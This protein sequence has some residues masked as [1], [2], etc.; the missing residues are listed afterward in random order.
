VSRPA[1]RNVQG[2]GLCCVDRVRPAP[3]DWT[4]DRLEVSV[5][6]GAR[7]L[8]LPAEV[9]AVAVRWYLRHGLSYRDVEELLA[10]R[11][12]QVDRVTVYRWVH[13][14]RTLPL[15]ATTTVIGITTAPDRSTQ[16]SRSVLTAAG[17][18]AVQAPR[19]NDKRSDEATGERRRFSSAI[20]P[21][22][23]RRSPKISDVLLLLH[24]H[25]LSGGNL[26]PAL[27][28]FRALGASADHE[29]D[30]VDV[31]DRAAPHQ[32]H[33]RTRFAS[34]GSGDGMQA[35]PSS[36]RPPAGRERTASGRPR[37]SWREVS[38]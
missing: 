7:R 37:S 23:C 21:A 15:T 19:V 25:G 16:Q 28:Q 12:I 14:T 5:V 38:R 3:G 34:R 20:L 4:G 30:R 31:R 17:A 18:I 33:P 35:H 8:S 10:E 1:A 26:V 6:I 2:G 29:P 27:E 32:D 11:G 9:I 22:W 36:A 24:L 13:R